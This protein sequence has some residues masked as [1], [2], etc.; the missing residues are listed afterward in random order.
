MARNP[1]KIQER[2]RLIAEDYNDLFFNQGKR[3]EVIL[4]ELADKYHLMER[5][6][7]RI[8]LRESRGQDMEDP[9]LKNQLKLFEE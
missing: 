8:V 2:N 5:T 9:E 6:I 7:Y 4:K 1:H 3:E